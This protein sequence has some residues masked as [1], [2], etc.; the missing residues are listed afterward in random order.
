[1]ENGNVQD[2]SKSLM[3]PSVLRLKADIA[4]IELTPEQIREG[5]DYMREKVY[6]QRFSDYW[7]SK[8]A[9]KMG[10]SHC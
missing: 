9:E 5:M 1:M 8:E 7:K 10:K 2:A 6:E 3:H 4:A